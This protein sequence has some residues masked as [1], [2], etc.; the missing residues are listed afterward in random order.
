[1]P[2]DASQKNGRAKNTAHQLRVVIGGR[3]GA[4]R[5]QTRA[6]LPHPAI[7]AVSLAQNLAV[8][9]CRLSRDL[10]NDRFHP[11]SPTADGA[12]FAD[13]WG[14]SDRCLCGVAA[15]RA[16]KRN[17]IELSNCSAVTEIGWA[18]ARAFRGNGRMPR[19]I[20]R[21]IRWGQCPAL[22]GAWRTRPPTLPVWARD[23][24]NR[25]H[26]GASPD[27]RARRQVRSGPCRAGLTDG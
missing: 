19:W 8:G 21:W 18:A 15:R 17:R 16:R 25:A 20:A 14:G 26:H 24:A 4:S 2:A 22:T 3:G 11:R 9:R 23:C 13:R 7:S 6:G 27:I 5:G 10:Q 1:M 12:A